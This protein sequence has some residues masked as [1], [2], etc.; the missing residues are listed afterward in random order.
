VRPGEGALCA[1]ERER[2]TEGGRKG[3]RERDSERERERETIR[4]PDSV[5]VLWLTES[6]GGGLKI[7]SVPSGFFY[8]PRI[9]Y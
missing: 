8:V 5:S 3:G 7:L 1:C 9:L 4:P 2:E 6:G